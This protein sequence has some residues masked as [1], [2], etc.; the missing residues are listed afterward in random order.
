MVSALPT[1]HMGLCVLKIF[2]L[3]II[4][5]SL[6]K[7][8]NAY[9]YMENWGPNRNFELSDSIVGRGAFRNPGT[10]LPVFHNLGELDNILAKADNKRKA[11]VVV[12]ENVFNPTGLSVAEQ[13]KARAEMNRKVGGNLPPSSVV[14][15]TGLSGDLS[16]QFAGATMVGNMG[17]MDNNDL[18]PYGMG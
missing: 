9:G 13:L 8:T 14:G 7:M 1:V 2:A 17:Y 11:G 6:W 16:S 18:N 4:A 12:Y 10:E 15:S 3:V 5:H